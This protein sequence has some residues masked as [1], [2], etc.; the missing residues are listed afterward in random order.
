MFNIIVMHFAMWHLGV[1]YRRY[2]TAFPWVLQHHI[3]TRQ[4]LEAQQA[5]R[6]RALARKR[7][8]QQQ[9]RRHA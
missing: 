5:A 8:Q 9:S 6:V 7:Q 4:R 1:L 3:S 2:H